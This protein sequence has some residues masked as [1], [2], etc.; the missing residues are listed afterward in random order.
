ML[1]ARQASLGLYVLATLALLL[2]SG[3]EPYERLTWWLE[4]VPVLVALPLL[5]LCYRRFKFTPL[6]YFLIF[7]C[8]ALMIIG[9]HYS[10]AHVPIGYWAMEAFGF[11]RNHYDRVGHFMQGFAPA[12]IARELL[13]GTSPL[14]AGSKWLFA[15]IVLGVTGISAIYE[16]AEWLAAEI[17]GIGADAF[18][19]MQGDEWDSQ[20]DMALAMGGAIVALLCFSRWQDRQLSR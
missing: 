17:L 3:I 6:V 7:I 16:L 5:M 4:V 18:L 13:L 20:K 8:F 12:L 19:G 14:K 2:W 15:I 1:R 9:S 11:E 10:Y